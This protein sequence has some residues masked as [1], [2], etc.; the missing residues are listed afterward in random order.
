MDLVGPIAWKDEAQ[1]IVYGPV[2]VPDMPDSDGDIVSAQKIEAVAHA[3]M[4]MYGNNDVDHSLINVGVPVE[5]FLAP[6]ELTFTVGSDQVTVPKGTW[7]MGVRVADDATWARIVKGELTGFSI[8]GVARQVLKGVA[9]LK[10]AS[11][12]A[13]RTTLR[14]LGP[15][16]LVTHVSLVD[17]PAVP[18]AKWL[19]VKGRS[20]KW[21]AGSYEQRREMVDIAL[22]ER[23]RDMN[24]RPWITQLFP[25]YA[26]TMDDQGGYAIMPYTIDQA[27]EKA[28]LGEPV[29]VKLETRILAKQLAEWER[30]LA[31]LKRGTAAAGNPGGVWQRLAAALSLAPSAKEGRRFAGETVDRLRSIY[32]EVKALLDEAETELKDKTKSQTTEKG[33]IEDMDETKLTELIGKA[34]DAKLAPLTE[35]LSEVEKSVKAAA[36][37]APAATEPPATTG[38]SEGDKPA[39]SADDLAAIKERM[40]KLEGAISGSRTLKGQ[41]GKDA[42]TKAATAPSDRDPWGRKARAS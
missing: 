10:A 9:G 34:L 15:D 14:D 18:M 29:P 25:D 6:Q 23:F 17:E 16:W 8:M 42:S 2:L 13:K 31:G 37:A 19:S 22:A 39:Q 27:G 3:F 35:R 40:D 4:E 30:E 20:K 26:L 21:I 32:T 36:P 7:I 33:G 24:T 5:S 41:D 12:A 38:K 1:R 11:A 28:T